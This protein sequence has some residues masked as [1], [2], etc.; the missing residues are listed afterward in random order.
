LKGA[1]TIIGVDSDPVRL[2]MAKQIGAD[3]VIDHSK[4]DAVKEILRMTGG[5]GV[6]VAI[7][8]LG[9]QQTFESSLR[10]V[11]PGGKLSSLG[12]YSGKLEVP[13]DAFSSRRRGG[14]K[15]SGVFPEIGNHVFHVERY[16]SRAAWTPRA[17]DGVGE[18][19]NKPSTRISSS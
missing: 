19:H 7:E 1:S 12:V 6:D 4:T 3:E 13:L 8:A 2:K 11:R 15:T 14:R 9:L 5:R 17:I 16:D 18:L 10:V